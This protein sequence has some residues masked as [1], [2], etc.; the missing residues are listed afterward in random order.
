MATAVALTW[1]QG[2]IVMR[3]TV[4]AELARAPFAGSSSRLARAIPPS[5]FGTSSLARWLEVVVVVPGV[6]VALAIAVRALP[7]RAITASAA[8]GRPRLV[9][10][11]AVV[12]LLVA[13]DAG[14]VL[15][16]PSGNGYQPRRSPLNVAV[17]GSP[18]T[19]YPGGE[20]NYRVDVTNESDVV[21]L[22]DMTLT[23]TLA[24]GMHLV[25]APKLLTGQ[26]CTGD[27]VVR[28]HLD[29]LAPRQ[30]T[31][32]WFGI[33][34]SEPGIHRLLARS[35]S[36]GFEGPPATAFDVPVGS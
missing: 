4:W 1:T 11:A 6:A 17:S 9:G 19:S 22:P 26:G 24:P 2:T 29:Y 3:N 31:T 23:L 30:P 28:C 8:T 34:F 12:A 5:I 18:A 7:P 35:S 25:G 21:L 20:V 15:G 33:Q 36:N 32:L 14:A 13:I 16:Y 27:V 10:A